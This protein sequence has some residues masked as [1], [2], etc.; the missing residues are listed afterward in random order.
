MQGQNHAAVGSNLNGALCFAIPAQVCLLRQSS[1]RFHTLHLRVSDIGRIYMYLSL[2]S[3]GQWI[4]GAYSMDT[5]PM[6]SVSVIDN[7]YNL[8][9]RV[10]GSVTKNCISDNS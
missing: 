7:L 1:A 4:T 8:F 10:Q 5:S 9:G 2:D 3:S 6:P